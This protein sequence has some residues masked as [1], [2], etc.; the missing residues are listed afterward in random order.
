MPPPFQLMLCYCTLAHIFRVL[1]SSGFSLITHPIHWE[2]LLTHLRIQ[3]KFT[4]GATIIVLMSMSGK[5]TPVIKNWG[6]LYG[7]ITRAQ[8]KSNQEERGAPKG[9]AARTTWDILRLSWKPWDSWLRNVYGPGQSGASEEWARHLLYCDKGLII[10]N[11]HKERGWK[12]DG[13]S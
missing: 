2:N 9:W 3:Q 11:S 13:I 6:V 4:L 5:V 10:R 1:V 8:W 12:L 7:F